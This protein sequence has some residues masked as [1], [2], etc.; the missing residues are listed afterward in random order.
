MIFFIT[1]LRALAACFIT[2]AHYTG[3]YPTDLIAN[4]GLIGDV[5][6]FAVSGYCLYNVKISFPRWYFK[7]IYRIY[8]PVLIMT[9]I[10]MLV[11]A[12][13]IADHSASW[14]YVYPTYY[15]FL[16]SI[17]VL[18]IPFYFIVRIDTLRKHILLIMGAIALVWLVVYV[19]IYNRSYYHIDTVREPMIRFLFMECLLLGAWFRQNNTEVRNNFK[20]WYPLAAVGMFLI[21]FSSK[22]LFSYK[23]S[24]AQLQILNQ[25]VI[26]ALLVLMFL[27][28]AGLDS[29]LE[30]LPGWIKKIITVISDMTLEIYIVQYVLIDLIRSFRHF[31]LNWI[32]LTAV[33]T[34]S[35]FVL[36][37]VCELIY[38]GF[39]KLS[40]NFGRGYR[41]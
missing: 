6:F 26:F 21:Y 10:Y 20:V 33:I 4:G 2:N 27:T 18:Y 17:I 19:T 36:H 13:S 5:L 29:K 32:V 15:H 25:I 14:W 3:I 37:K 39:D 9:A 1:F 16:A 31:P 35:A 23:E 7:R 12:Y 30:K 8:P 28:F 11:G 22:S 34:V 38:A 40:E 24:L 41:S